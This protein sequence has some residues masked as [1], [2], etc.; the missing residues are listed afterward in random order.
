[1]FCCG[2]KSSIEE[3]KRLE[4]STRPTGPCQSKKERR[5]LMVDAAPELAPGEISKARQA[6]LPAE[7]QQAFLLGR[8][9]GVRTCRFA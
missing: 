7:L 5:L 1:M 8:L 4:W 3:P 2:S 9:M 6:D